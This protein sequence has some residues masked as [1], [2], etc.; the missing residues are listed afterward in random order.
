MAIPLP[1]IDAITVAREFVNQWIYMFGAPEKVLSDNGTQFKSEVMAVVNAI[2]G[3]EQLLTSIYHPESNGIIEKFHSF[4]KEKLK[5]AALQYNLDYFG[6]D[7]WDR[8]IPSI[9]H[10]YNITPHTTTKYA[11]F[12]LLFGRPPQLPLSLIHI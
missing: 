3:I 7:D 11:P 5:I 10:A 6:V 2:M 9:T 8:F 12:E 4:L 1:N